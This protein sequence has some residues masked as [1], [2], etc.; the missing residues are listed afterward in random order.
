MNWILAIPISVRLAAIGVA[1]VFLGGLVN[2]AIYRLAWRPRSI[3]P[4]SL[5]DPAAPPRQLGDRLPILG[6]LGL[7]RESPLHGRGFWL[8]PLAV[9]L[10]CGACLAALYWW[11]IVE[12]GLLPVVLPPAVVQQISLDLH[13]R[14]FCHA[15][16]ALLMLVASLI[17]IDEKTI[18]DA[19]TVPGTLFGLLAATAY[20]PVLLPVI[21]GQGL[22]FLRITTPLDWPA[23]LSGP[24]GLAIAIACWWLWCVALMPRTWYTRHGVGRAFTLMVARLRRERATLQFALLG[25][26][27][28]AGIGMVWVWS[29]VRWQGLLTALVGLAAS[30]GAIW[31]VRVMGTLALR[32]EAMGFGDVTLM[33][34]LGTLLG[35]QGCLM[36][37]FLAP[38]AGLVIGLGSLILNRGPEI[39]Y[40]PFLCLAA[41]VVIV[42]WG[43][44]W[45]WA[46][47]IFLLGWFVPGVLAVCLVL[48]AGMLFAWRLVLTALGRQ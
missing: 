23:W 18:P 16:L 46:E 7:R 8:R 28:T 39:P 31:A 9:E 42:R 37:F 13:L 24:R 30:G 44:F 48:M 1:G 2:L 6:W 33:A 15:V 41:T 29:G 11:E 40:G 35:W 5:P 36:V 14:F 20:P 32:R 43:A 25:L 45:E 4:W 34:M 26:V 22:E 19:I 21:G 17:D 47:G 10:L 12:Q 27:G 38:L 3:S